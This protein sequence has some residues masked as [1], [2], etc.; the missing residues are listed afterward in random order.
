MIFFPFEWATLDIQEVLEFTSYIFCF[1]DE[2]FP[3]VTI[4]ENY[5]VEI[6]EMREII[7]NEKEYGLEI[8]VSGHPKCIQKASGFDGFLT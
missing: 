5:L 6:E 3:G 8:M 1:F 4:Y 7:K 2:N